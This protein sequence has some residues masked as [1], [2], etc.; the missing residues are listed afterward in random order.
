[1]RHDKLEKELSLLL[2]LTENHNYTI[3]ELCEKLSLSRRMLYYYLESFRDW[4]FIVEK[5]GHHYSIDR[6]SPYFKHLFET[7]NFTE[8][9]VLTMMNIL[10]KVGDRN[11][12]VERIKRRLDQ[13]Y[14]FNILANSELRE[15]VAHNVSL[16]YEAIKYKR[17]VKIHN[18]SSP[19][20]Q[21]VTDRIVEPFLFMN[22]N[23]DVRCYEPA[24]RMGKTFKVSRMGEVVVLDREWENEGAHKQVFTDLFMFSGEEKYPVKLRLGQP[25]RNLMLEEY[26]QS[27]PCLT[28]DG[29]HHWVF[30]TEV[31][32][33]LGIGRFILGLY[34]DI[35]ILGDEGLKGYIEGKVGSW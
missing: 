8:D 1:M 33:Y 11:A 28:P 23:N 14:D 18:Y 35:E 30:A 26:P 5:R 31:V 10:S 19:H 24:S 20:S 25:S 34:D 12:V 6:R 17:M 22:N 27:A 15:H 21:T 29:P 9:E 32:G 4:G 7:I 16:L 13:F 3:N 2:C